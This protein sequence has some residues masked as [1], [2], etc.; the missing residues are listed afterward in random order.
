MH[1]PIDFGTPNAAQRMFSITKESVM[2]TD[3]DKTS[4]KDKERLDAEAMKEAAN[5]ADMT[6]S[7]ALQDDAL[8][9]L[10]GADHDDLEKLKK[11]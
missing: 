9:R 6:S 1:G 10:E 4:P 8:T 2:T 11:S 3:Q 5:A 7:K